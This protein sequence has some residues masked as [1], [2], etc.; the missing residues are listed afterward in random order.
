MDQLNFGGEKVASSQKAIID[1][2]TSL[3]AGP[4]EA[5]KALAAKVGATLLMGKH[6]RWSS[7]RYLK[8]RDRP[9]DK[10]V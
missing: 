9:Q 7:K 3:L 2:G 10:V 5:V 8:S 4:S 1:S 6:E